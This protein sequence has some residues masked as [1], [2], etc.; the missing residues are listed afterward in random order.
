MANLF[1]LYMHATALN[2]LVRLR[3]WVV[4]PPPQTPRAEVPREALSQPA[5]KRFFNQ[6]RKR[7]PLG[8]GH[9]CTW[10]MRLIKVAARIKDTTRRVLVQLSGSWPYLDHYRQVGQTVLA[11]AVPPLDTG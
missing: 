2:L 9:P 5:R 8:E 1:R 7:D 11:R 4:D 10:R 3:T 6:R